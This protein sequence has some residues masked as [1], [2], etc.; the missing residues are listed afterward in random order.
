[1]AQHLKITSQAVSKWERGTALPDI[2]MFPALSA[3]FGVSIDELF[4]MSDE[5]RM[6]RIQN[7]L[8]EVRFCNPADI[9]NERLFLIEKARRE[10]ENSEPYELLANLELHLAKEHCSMAE[11][12][13]LEAMSRNP[14]SGKGIAALANAMGGRHVDP[15]NNTHNALIDRYKRHIARYPRAENTYSWLIE[16]LLDDGRLDEAHK[17]FDAYAELDDGYYMLMLRI[18]LTFAR[19]ERQTANELLR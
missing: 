4:S 19:G 1:M 7:M 11:E 2:G 10:P 18:K 12:Y 8:W 6:E 9:E 14:A 5:T 3:Y 15:R 17:Y 16:Q 13:A